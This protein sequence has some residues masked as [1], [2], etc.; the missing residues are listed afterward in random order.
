MQAATLRGRRRIEPVAVRTARLHGF[1][2]CFD[3]PVG[4]G[5]RGVANLRTA[6]GA[7]VWGVAYLLTQE[8]HEHLDRTEGVPNGLYRR[9]S[10]ELFTDEGVLVAETLI[11]ES[12]D[13]A[14]LPSHRYLELLREG[15]REHSLPDAWLAVLEAWKLAWDEREGAFNP[16]GLPRP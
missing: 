14:R 15:A 13:A 11:S 9:I 1:E 4:P 6:E 8:Q 5:A 10:V 7:H 2:L 16:E 3:I 12:R